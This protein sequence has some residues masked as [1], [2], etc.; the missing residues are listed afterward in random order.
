MIWSERLLR[1]ANAWGKKGKKAILKGQIKF[2]NRKGEKFDWDNDN[3]TEINMAYKEQKLV[4]PDFIAEIPGIEVDRYY[5]PIRGP[6][7][8]TEPEVKSSYAERANNARKNSDQKTDVVTQSK[9]RGVDDDEDD[10]SVIEIE[11]SDDESDGGVYPRINQ[12]AI[13]VED[14]PAHDDKD[15]PTSLAE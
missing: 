9:T 5:E 14:M 7:P 13:K 3:L 10:A 4:Q 15:N 6:K 11:E 1:K 2:M 8:N 12:E